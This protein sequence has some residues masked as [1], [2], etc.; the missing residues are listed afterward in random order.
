M[1]LPKADFF[2][3]MDALGIALTYDDVRLKTGHSETMPANVNLQSRFS[4]NI[5]LQMPIVSA[6]MDTVTEHRLAIEMAKLGGLG[7]IHKNMTP[8]QQ[9]EEVYR[10]KN[11][12]NAL[13]KNPVTVFENDA[14]SAVLQM[15]RERN[16]PFHTFPVLNDSGNLVGI[17]SQND[18]DF[19]DDYSLPISDIMT[20]NLVMGAPGIVLSNAYKHMRN[21]KKKVFPL[22]NHSTGKLV[23][24]Y[25]FS[26][27]SRIVRGESSQYNLDS[28]GQLR[29]GA[30]IGTGDETSERLEQL[31]SNGA[32]VI[33]ID[34][35]HGDSTPVLRVLEAA[36]KRYSH[37][38]I[39]VGNVSESKSVKRLVD[40]GANGIKIGQGP[41]SICTTRIVAG[42]GCP[43]V[44][45]VYSAA[46]MAGEIPVCADGGLRYSGD[47]PIAIGAGA[48]SVMMGSM[49]AGTDES[50]GE[51]V[52]REGRRW[53][54]YRGMGSLGAMQDH[55]G[56]RERYRQD[57]SA[58]LV[59][60]GIEGLVPYK[61]TLGEVMAQY[62]GGLRAG[63]GY[64][65]ATSILEL[66]EKAD[67]IRMTAAGKAE[68]HP[69]DVIITRE[70]PNY[71]GRE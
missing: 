22:V 59:P 30:A 35:A 25:I 54:S 32:D 36:K 56:S 10:V 16:L 64:V 46:L 31:I 65:G 63:M 19:C 53:K 68:S 47:I 50:P 67:F 61:G 29:V 27:V 60:E 7:I 15:R 21:A 12:L 51:I 3:K 62:V 6:A 39:V 44:T 33:V 5:P 24:M 58:T 52:F 34:T 18:F 66:Q 1:K 8:E 55:Q 28:N 48:S 49:L 45:A 13:I 69:H 43:Q 70:A 14:V 11:H 2:A 57:H 37:I 41:G 42:I 26:D 20:T 17:V 40:A 4:Q 9:G 38:D 23:G 71:R